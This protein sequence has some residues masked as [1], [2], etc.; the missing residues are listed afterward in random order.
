[1]K[2]MMIALL[3]LVCLVMIQGSVFAHSLAYDTGT[4][5]LTD[6]DDGG[7]EDLPSDG[8]GGDGG[9]SS[10]GEGGNE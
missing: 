7:T 10:S 9:D 8:D 1:M 3:L 4:V 5:A 2:R 6:G